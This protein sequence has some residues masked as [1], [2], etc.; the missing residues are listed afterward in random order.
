MC[1]G[2]GLCHR[3]RNL[4]AKL[5]QYASIDQCTQGIRGRQHP[6]QRPTY[7][8]RTAVTRTN[9]QTT[10]SFADAPAIGV[11]AAH[12]HATRLAAAAGPTLFGDRTAIGECACDGAAP[13]LIG[14]WR[15]WWRRWRRW[16]RR[17]RLM[18]LCGPPTAVAPELALLERAAARGWSASRGWSAWSRCLIGSSCI[19][20]ALTPCA[21]VHAR[22]LTSVSVGKVTFDRL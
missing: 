17:G 1:T 2:T 3:R 20:V 10:G 21:T 15:R 11:R 8:A 4:V 18:R 13:P 5:A 12:S 7:T 19:L 6:G 16:R 22:A 14:Q 9:E